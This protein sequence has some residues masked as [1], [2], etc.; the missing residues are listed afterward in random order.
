MQRTDVSSFRHP[1]A[2]PLSILFG[3]GRPDVEKS[4]IRLFVFDNSVVQRA[5]PHSSSL[6]DISRG[7][8]RR[9]NGK[10]LVVGMFGGAGGT[11][12]CIPPPPLPPSVLV[13][14]INSPWACG[15][16]I[17]TACHREEGGISAELRPRGRGCVGVL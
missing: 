1:S 2:S 8:R 16:M 3:L 4:S 10:K 7:G 13:C 6:A 5:R 15:I 9:T 14:V 17:S 11:M 12:I